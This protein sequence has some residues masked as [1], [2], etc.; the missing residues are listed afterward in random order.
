MRLAN[1]ALVTSA[2]MPSRLKTLAELKAS[3]LITCKYCI[4]IGS[5]LA[6]HEGIS[7]AQLRP[8]VRPAWHNRGLGV[9]I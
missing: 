6:H 2:R 9:S 3:T 5:A 1:L 8:T 4:D 7:E